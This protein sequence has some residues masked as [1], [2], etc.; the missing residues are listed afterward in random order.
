MDEGEARFVV[1]V[2]ARDQGFDFDGP[3]CWREV[4]DLSIEVE[5]LDVHDELHA[6]FWKFTL[7]LDSGFD[8]DAGLTATDL[9]GDEDADH[10]ERRRWHG[11]RSEAAVVWTWWWCCCLCEEGV[12]V[13]VVPGI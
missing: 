11:A 9:G 8:D 6:A 2:E 1:E 13:V 3:L 12:M 7:G 5:D 4:E 10:A